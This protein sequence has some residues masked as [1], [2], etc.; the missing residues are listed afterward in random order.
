MTDKALRYQ[1]L[2]ERG[3]P[4]HTARHIVAQELN[5]DQVDMMVVCGMLPEP[6]PLRPADVRAKADALH[7]LRNVVRGSLAMTNAGIVGDVRSLLADYDQQGKMIEQL[8]AKVH[9]LADNAQYLREKNRDAWGGLT[10]AS[11]QNAEL[12]RALA[13]ALGGLQIAHANSKAAMKLV[14]GAYMERADAVLA[15][16]SHPVAPEAPLHEWRCPSCGETTRARMADQ[17]PEPEYLV[18]RTVEDAQDLIAGGVAT[19]DQLT[20]AAIILNNEVERLTGP[21]TC[22]EPNWT[23]EAPDE[24]SQD[25]P[26]HGEGP[27]PKRDPSKDVPLINGEP[28]F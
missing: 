9:R 1:E 17:E 13:N 8:A 20:R 6:R 27:P 15:S 11:R 26:V 28:A 18:P 19:N 23:G 24:P 4:D 2:I 12:R 22:C 25:C 21:C 3:Y 5:D 16:T 14:I 7:R 10:D